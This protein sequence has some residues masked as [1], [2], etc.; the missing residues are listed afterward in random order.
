MARRAVEPNEPTS[1]VEDAGDTAK[2]MLAAIV[3]SAEDAI[4]GKTLDGIVT[5]WNGAAERIFGYS[6]AEMVGQPITLLATP[7]TVDE[8]PR[9]LDAIRRGERIGHYETRRRCKDGR[10]IDVAL[11]V[12][13]ILNSAGRIVGASKIARDITD[14]KRTAAALIE[15]EALL[16]SILDTI[17]DGMVV[18]DEQ[19][20]VQ[21]FSAEAERMFGYIADEVCGRNVNMLMASPYRENH[22]GYLARYLATGERRIIGLGRVVTG[23]RK[24]GAVFPLELSVGEVPADGHRLF[25][26]FVH[27]LTQHQQTLK[28]VQELQSELSHVSR[29]TEMGQMA[30]A[31]AHEVNQP[32]TAATNYLEAGRRVLARA[33]AA[34]VARAAGIIENASAQVVRAAAIIHRLREFVRKGEGERRPEALGRLVEEAIALA[35]VGAPN[36]RAKIDLCIAPE[37]PELPVDR[38][39]IEQ[40]VVNLVRNAIEAMDGGAHQQLTVTA[41]SGAGSVEISVADTGPGIAPEVAERL[42]QPFVTSKPNGM[43]VGLSICRSI[44]EAHGG[45]LVAQPNPAG[46]AIFRFSLPV[47][48]QS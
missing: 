10:I 28:R 22:D 6:A 5:S 20:I 7:E 21:S 11:A 44:I 12:S 1:E 36:A 31:L 48:R 47:T 23:R 17:P 39:Q 18:I 43:G 26:G 25:T 4:V 46:G 35:L 9:I 14:A 16:Q 19:G 33:D 29:L 3:E 45:A 15:R 27:D 34:A 24:D 30:S 38:V 40:V 42:F 2:S 37:L 41:A 13:P 32:L 8:M